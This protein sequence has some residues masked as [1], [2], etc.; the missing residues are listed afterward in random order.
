VNKY[1]I[2]PVLFISLAVVTYFVAS[3]GANKNT[4]RRSKSMWANKNTDLP[5][6]IGFSMLSYYYWLEVPRELPRQFSPDMI[7][8]KINH[9]NSHNNKKVLA[10]NLVTINI[11]SH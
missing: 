8:K 1:L 5:L 4:T 11:T 7:E 2:Y 3:M 6:D 9:R 10:N